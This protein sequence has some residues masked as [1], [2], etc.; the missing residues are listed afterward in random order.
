MNVC[1]SLGCLFRYAFAVLT[2]MANVHVWHGNTESAA[3]CLTNALL[4]D[5]TRP[6][7]GVDERACGGCRAHAKVL[8]S[9]DCSRHAGTDT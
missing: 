1:A 2:N 9:L 8:R 6:G 4:L 7:V 5:G 3:H